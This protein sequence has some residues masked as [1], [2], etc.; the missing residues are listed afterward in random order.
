MT[1]VLVTGANGFVGKELCRVLA[2]SGYMVCA[3]LR[4]DQPTPE[5]S[6]AK[7]V[8]GDIGSGTRWD[9]ALR[10][11]EVVL[12]LAARAHVLHDKAAAER[13]YLETN[14]Q[15]T[16]VL[17]EAAARAGVRRFV[18]LSSVK[19]N[20]EATTTRPYG[21]DDAPQPQDAYGRSKWLGEQHLREIA[22]RAPLEAVIVRSPLV[23]GPGVR[24]NFL[25]LLRL[26][27]RQWPLPFGAVDNRRSLV[28][29]DNLCGLLAHV[30]TSPAAAGRTWMA[31]DGDDLST[32]ELVRRMA[33]I[34]ERRARL[35]PVPV[36]IL[37]LGAGLCGYRA[38]FERLCSSLVVDVRPTVEVLGWTAPV[39]V[40]AA[41]KRTVD[42]YFA[43][44]HADAA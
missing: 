6:T 16:R 44:K 42:W 7:A 24:A 28:S 29:V 19:V 17:A 23:Y 8:V 40:D 35:I 18:Y 1:R 13:L 38:E 10:D 27:D 21:P 4:R 5:G 39:S 14:E 12:H 31:A 33:R 26:V 2:R 43:Q 41:L 20:G 3:A 15:G 9:E 34:M 36:G 11:V 25:R 37:M 32:P 22:A 30:V